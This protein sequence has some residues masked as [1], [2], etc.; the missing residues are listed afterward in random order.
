[1]SM[2]ALAIWRTQQ[3]ILHFAAAAFISRYCSVACATPASPVS[4][5]FL[6]APRRSHRVIVIWSGV[7]MRL[8]FTRAKWTL[9]S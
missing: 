6:V 5:S 3:P 9:A 8:Q 7:G 1:M 4:T 2:T